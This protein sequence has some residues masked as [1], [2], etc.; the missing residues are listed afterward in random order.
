MPRTLLAA[1]LL[2]LPLTACTTRDVSI[3]AEP[4]W[5]P[6]SEVT[7][8]AMSEVRTEV[9]TEA[10]R[11]APQLGGGGAEVSIPRPSGGVLPAGAADRVLA[12][13]A[14]PIVKLLEAG[15]EPRSDLSYAL[16]RGGSQ[17]LALAMDMAVTVKSNGQ[18]MP[19]MPM[20][21]MTMTF[22]AL[23]ADKSASGELKIDAR[24]TGTSVEPAGGQQEQM[25]RALRPQLD[26]MKGLGMLY[27]VTP[28]GRVHDLALDMPASVPP[29]AQQLMSVVSQSFES[30]VTPLPQE[31][32]GIGA[33]WQV[34]SRLASGGADILQS[35]VYTLRSRSG[36]RAGLDVAVVQVAAGDTIH[37]PQMPAGMSAKLKSFRSA[38]S[39]GTQVDLQS[40]A[41]ESGNLSLKRAVEITVQGSGA[42]DESLVETTTAVTISRP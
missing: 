37:T 40:V 8:E 6:M 20:P 32:V 38:G 22:A 33:R 31:A 14:P 9:R 1:L 5:P 10:R 18:S 30:M 19:S 15:A 29:A 36:A 21:R 11:E 3:A 34:V 13:G 17:A 42:D 12:V 23:T 41:P 28:K 24:L 39:G 35:A 4:E 26:A 27:W 2:A 7:T 16:H 25:A